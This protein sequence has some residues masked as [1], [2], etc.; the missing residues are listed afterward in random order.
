MVDS[1]I[2]YARSDGIHIAYRIYGEGPRDIVLIPGTL[3]NVDMYWDFPVN[4]YLL[5]RLTSFARVIVFDKRGQGLSDRIGEHTLEERIGDLKAVMDAAGSHRAT[6][7]GWSE[8]GPMSLMFTATYPGRTSALVLCGSFA[9]MRAELFNISEAEWEQVLRQFE[10]HWGEGI[11]VPINAPSRRKDKP[12]VEWFARLERATASPGAIVALFRANFGIDVRPILPSIQVPTLVL[13]RVGDKTVPFPAGRYLAENIRGAKFIELPGDDHLLQAY[14]EELLD[15]LLDEVEEF[16]T[17]T[18]HRPEPE[19][20]LATVMFTDIVNSTVHAAQMG[21]HQ[22]RALLQQYYEAVGKELAAYQGHQVNTAGDGVLATFQGPARAIRCACA[23][24]ERLK[25]LGLQVRTG[26]HT[27]ECELMGD[28]VGGIA[29]HIGA[30][31]EAAANPD[32]VLVSST[33]KDLVAGSGIKFVDRGIHSLKGVP[34][35]WR[36]FGVQL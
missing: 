9:S 19:R 33:V 17:G 1:P 31:V 35:R 28:D 25:P 4:E 29:V 8:G 34:E 7:F 6:I 12:F 23:I 22:W 21:D 5:R 14:D 18:R 30:R 36:L 2:K 11:L 13:H 27:G 32:E 3:S 16:I 26:L 24:R 10:E 15:R 20:V